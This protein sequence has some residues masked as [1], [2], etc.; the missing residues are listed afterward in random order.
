MDIERARE[1][2]ATL[3]DGVN[4][5]TGEVLD[6]DNVCNQPDIIRALHTAVLALSMRPITGDSGMPPNSGKVWTRSADEK[7]CQMF[8]AGWS[9]QKICEA[10]GRSVDGVAARLVRLGKIAERNE[11]RKRR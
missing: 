4:P 6:D 1:L 10:M 3:A 8:E 11:F 9:A 5:L 2:L 7:L